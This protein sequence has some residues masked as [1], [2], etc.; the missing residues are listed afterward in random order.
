MMGNPSCEESGDPLSGG[1]EQYADDGYEPT[2]EQRGA[3]FLFWTLLLGI[4]ASFGL[5]DSRRYA[6]NPW[7][8]PEGPKN[9]E[10]DVTNN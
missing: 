7:R 5:M 1:C 8:R 2:L 3:R 9:R 10:Y 4:P 6:A